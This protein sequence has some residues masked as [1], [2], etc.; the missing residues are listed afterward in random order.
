MYMKRLV[1]GAATAGALAVALPSTATAATIVHVGAFPPANP[2]FFITSGTPTTSPITANFGATLTGFSKSFDDIF[3]FTIPQNG[4]GSGSLST[5]F[6]SATNELTI[7]DVLINSISYPVTTTSSGQSLTVN[8]IPIHDGVLNTVEV[9]G[10][11]SPN[12]IAATYTGTATFSA[13]AIPEPASWL[14]TI[15]G[16]SLLGVAMRRRRAQAG[17]A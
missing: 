6:S 1:L 15:G 8:G 17:L 13:T 3:E 7:T 5:S 11:T 2:H 16:F 10:V 9:V 4:V 14:M 12:N